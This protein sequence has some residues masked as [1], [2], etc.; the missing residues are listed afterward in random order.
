MGQRATSFHCFLIR[1]M[2][3]IFLA[4]HNDRLHVTGKVPWKFSTAMEMLAKT[5]MNESLG[6]EN[7]QQDTAHGRM[8]NRT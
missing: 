7:R 6:Q 5:T 3:I 4:R 2:K 1:E 8:G